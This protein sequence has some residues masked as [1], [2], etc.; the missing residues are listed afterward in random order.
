MNWADH[1]TLGFLD[2]KSE[3]TTYI[4]KRIA[5]LKKIK[6]DSEFDY[7]EVQGRVSELEELLVFVSKAKVN[8]KDTYVDKKED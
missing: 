1:E 7:C 6:L 8:L 2:F 4:Q 5:E 3:M